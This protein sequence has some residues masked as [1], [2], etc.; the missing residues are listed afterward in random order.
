MTLRETAEYIAARLDK[1][2]D[3][4]LIQQLEYSIK[5]WRALL[6]RRDAE[7]N[8]ESS[9]YLQG[10]EFDLI[11]VDQLDPCSA[12]VGC[13]VLRSKNRIPK[14]VRLKDGRLFKFVGEAGIGT[15]K[16][17]FSY[18]EPENLEYTKHNKF[19]ANVIRYSYYNG[20]VYVFNNLLYRK[21]NIEFVFENPE[22]FISCC[23]CYS[24][25]YEFPL[26]ADM[27]QIIIQG[28]LTNEFKLKPI[29]QEV[30]ETPKPVAETES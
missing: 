19:T 1:P 7:V 6:I 16:K 18:V 26:P 29:D 22:E 27:I 11:K 9:L 30:K 24:D 10:M 25:D 13:P 14:P 8:Q 21:I 4:V 3:F 2:N 28:I 23:D 20:Y 5:I 17:I 15:R 12:V